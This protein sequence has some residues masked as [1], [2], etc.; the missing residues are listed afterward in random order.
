MIRC[1]TS[2]E[3][4]CLKQDQAKAEAEKAG[5]ED[6]TD[7]SE[8]SEN[9]EN[10]SDTDSSSDAEKPKAPDSPENGDIQNPKAEK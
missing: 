4:E 3:E 7:V 5:A 2:K 1:L 10:I 8:N 9:A 6:G